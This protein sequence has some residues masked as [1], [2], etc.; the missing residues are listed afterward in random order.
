MWPENVVFQSQR[1]VGH[2]LSTGW[3]PTRSVRARQCSERFDDCVVAVTGDENDAAA[4]RSGG[5]IIFTIIGPKGSI[6]SC[7]GPHVADP[8]LVERLLACFI[9]GCVRAF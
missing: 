8:F 1:H 7:E 9:L 6:P 4:A 5:R 3:Q 2:W